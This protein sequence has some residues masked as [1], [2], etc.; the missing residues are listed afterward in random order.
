M[1]FDGKWNLDSNYGFND[2]T[3]LR[4]STKFTI[5][6]PDDYS[7]IPSIKGAF[8]NGCWQSKDKIQGD[9]VFYLKKTS[10]FKSFESSNFEILSD[11][12]EDLKTTKTVVEITKRMQK[13]A[14]DFFGNLSNQYFL[15]DSEFYNQN[16]IVGFDLLLNTLRPIS[17]EEQFELK[18]IQVLMRKLV[19]YKFPDNYRQNKWLAD[20][21][22]HYLFMRYLEILFSQTKINRKFSRFPSVI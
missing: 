12:A 7:I 14:E 5:C 2:R 6:F 17:K 11:M 1:G 19:K 16:P 15:I 21:L 20:G 10:S 3:A 18:A 9:L 22:S 8:Q 4:S 13:F